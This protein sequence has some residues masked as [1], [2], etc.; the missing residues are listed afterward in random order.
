M[1]WAIV[2]PWRLGIAGIAFWNVID[3]NGLMWIAGGWW[4]VSSMSR[5][6]NGARWVADNSLKFRVNGVFVNGKM[7]IS[8]AASALIKSM[9]FFPWGRPPLSKRPFICVRPGAVIAFTKGVWQGGFSFG[10]G[11][12]WL[13]YVKKQAWS[14]F[15]NFGWISISK[16]NIL[17]IEIIS[18]CFRIC[19]LII[20]LL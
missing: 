2:R 8:L 12:A 19:S 18:T 20:F 13:D 11:E 9:M 15:W 10:K 4:R 6:D 16:K 3:G 1:F 17:C 14:L 7:T 5:R